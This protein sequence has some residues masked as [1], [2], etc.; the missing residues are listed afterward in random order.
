MK[1]DNLHV[2]ILSVLVKEVLEE[3]GDRLVGDVAT[4]HNVPEKGDILAE[5]SI[6]CLAVKVNIDY[7]T[8][9]NCRWIVLSKGIKMFMHSK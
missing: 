1:E 2:H 8:D 4:H 5:K 3:V 9:F 6:L 7:L